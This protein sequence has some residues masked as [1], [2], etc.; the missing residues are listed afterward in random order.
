MPG[1]PSSELRRFGLTVGGIFLFL[2]VLSRWRGH[3]WPPLV[4]WALGAMLVLPGLLAPTLLGP[5]RHHWMRGAAL[6][7]E[8]NS[9]IILAV[10]Y[11][12]V[13]APVGFVLRVFFRDPLDRRLDD[14]KASNW[15]RRTPAPVDRARYEQQF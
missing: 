3:D 4:L 7:G 11:I 9:R 6:L 12:V 10:F 15:I 1:A 2:G 8:V 5:V 13:L 14:G